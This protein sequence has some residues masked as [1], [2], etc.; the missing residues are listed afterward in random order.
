MLIPSGVFHRSC[1]SG[2]PPF[3]SFFAFSSHWS[4]DASETWYVVVRA[5][6]RHCCTTPRGTFD[7]LGS[8]CIVYFRH[9]R[10]KYCLRYNYIY[11]SSLPQQ[12]S[13]RCVPIP[14]WGYSPQVIHSWCTD[15]PICLRNQTQRIVFIAVGALIQKWGLSQTAHRIM[16]FAVAALIEKWCNTSCDRHGNRVAYK[17]VCKLKIMT[18]FHCKIVQL[19]VSSI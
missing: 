13:I 16:F 5:Q 8:I 11:V 10:R 17:K 2:S 19:S 12:I 15:T 9:Y 1:V 6:V 18:F 14:W 3:S 7:N 4:R